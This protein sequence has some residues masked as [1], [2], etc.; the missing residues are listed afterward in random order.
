MSHIAIL[1]PLEAGRIAAGE[2]IDR[3]S[4]LLREFIDNAI[5]AGAETIDATIREGGID[6]LEVSDNGCG[7]GEEDLQLCLVNHATSK[8]RRLDDLL[9]T[10]T[11]G[12]RGEALF[13][14]ASVADLEILSS[15]DG[16]EAWLLESRP[17]QEQHLRPA[18]RTGGTTVRASGLFN[19]IPARKLFLKRPS[20]EARS[21]KQVFIDK[22]L[23]FPAKTFRL[24]S[25]GR[26]ELLLP[27]AGHFLE[28]FCAAQEVDEHFMHELYGNGEGFDFT[29]L[30]GGPELFREDK[31]E[32]YL[33][34]N[35]HRVQ[36]YA[37]LQAFEY[38]LQGAFPNGTHPIGAIFLRIEPSLADFNIHTAKRE[39]RFKDAASIHHSI[40]TNLTAFTHSLLRKNMAVKDRPWY[41]QYSSSLSMEALLDEGVFEGGGTEAEPI[42]TETIHLQAPSPA[43][44]PVG[45]TEALYRGSL[46]TLFLVM[47]TPEAIYLVDRHAAHERLLFDRYRSERVSGDRLLVPIHFETESAE[48]EAFL[49]QKQ[50]EF[51]ERGLEL[52]GKGGLWEIKALPPGWNLAD[53]ETVRAILEIKNAG[54]DFLRRWA[55]T[56]ACHSA[57]KD[58][59]VLDNEAAQKLGEEA[60]ALDDPHCPHG[61]P[62][63]LRLSRDYLLRSIRRI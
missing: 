29:I 46:Y 26:A 50:A 10:R 54:E 13:S 35:G 21:C 30:A 24:N 2:V 51:G 58:G 59:T 25:N 20:A 27:A 57:I 16:R 48:D 49:Q 56:A 6:A 15:T 17:G 47:E 40:T 23:P 4:A 3:P 63:Y 33:F 36:D 52:E 61:R 42:P 53:G 19:S 28:R 62:I 45:Q 12:F 38:G 60:L 34:V 18:Y 44:R 43:P 8:I 22:A 37:L 14:A 5:D 39:V 9:S 55:A 41:P 31:K 1:P 11:M 32:Q 7:M